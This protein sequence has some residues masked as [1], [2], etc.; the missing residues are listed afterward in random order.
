VTQL[1]ALEELVM[2]SLPLDPRRAT[3]MEALPTEAFSKR[4]DV[5]YHDLTE[6]SVTGVIPLSFPLL[7]HLLCLLNFFC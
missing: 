3:P 1:P 4:I 2:A 5:V 6:R 7:T